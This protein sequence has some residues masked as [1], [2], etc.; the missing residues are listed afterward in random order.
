MFDVPQKALL[1][2]LRVGLDGSAS[3]MDARLMAELSADEWRDMLDMANVHGVAAIAVDGLNRLHE[4][5]DFC[6]ALDDA[7][8]MDIR[9]A[10]M[11][12]QLTYEQLYGAKW[13]TA[14]FV[15]NY[16]AENGIDT[17]CLKGFSF[18][19]Y[20]PIPEHRHGSDFDCFLSDWTRGNRLVEKQGVKVDWSEAKHSH[21]TV[22]GLHFE[23]H[24]TCIGINGSKKDKVLERYLQSVMGAAYPVQCAFGAVQSGDATFNG[25][26]QPVQEAAHPVQCAYESSIDLRP[27]SKVQCGYAAVQGPA[28]NGQ[29]MAER[30]GESVIGMPTTL[31]NAL[32][33]IKHAQHHFLVEDGITLRHVCDWLMIRRSPSFRDCRDMFCRD[34]ERFG[35]MP[36]VAPLDEVADVIAGQRQEQD[37]SANAKF[38]LNDILAHS[39]ATSSEKPKRKRRSKLHAYWGMLR[40]MWANRQRFRSFSTTSAPAMMCRYVIGHLFDHDA[41]IE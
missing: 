3:A 35:L 30:I 16:W 24:Q 33:C 13:E 14:S 19:Q 38:L 12:Q 1:A 15:A 40:Q 32:F 37:I 22:R 29:Q 36:F 5:K 8:C 9:Y 7:S 6:Y 17:Y 34:A 26:K 31:F 28:D 20:Y 41:S 4:R 25:C 11:G 2:L 10:W 27:G 39:V 23:N 21:F 18:A